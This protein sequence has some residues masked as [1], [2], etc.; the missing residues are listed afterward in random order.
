MIAFVPF[1]S[2]SFADLIGQPLGV[3]AAVIVSVSPMN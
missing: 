3:K 1:L 2:A